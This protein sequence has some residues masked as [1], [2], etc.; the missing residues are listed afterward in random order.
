ME[1]IST[2]KLEP[3]KTKL[4]VLKM[5]KPRGEMQEIPARDQLYSPLRHW[6]EGIDCCRLNINKTGQQH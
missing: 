5:P 6:K 3:E 2:L 1:K 4:K